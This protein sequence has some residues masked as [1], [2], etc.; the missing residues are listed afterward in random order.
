VTHGNTTPLDPKVTSPDPIPQGQFT[1]TLE[2]AG[3]GP[4]LAVRVR[5]F[6]KLAMRAYGL[7]CVPAPSLATQAVPIPP[8]DNQQRAGRQKPE[9]PSGDTK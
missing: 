7:R 4:P 3:I 2:A 1:I 8:T 6:L 9:T 5:K